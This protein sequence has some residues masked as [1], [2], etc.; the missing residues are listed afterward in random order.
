MATINK[1]RERERKE[2][3]T[4]RLL[5]Y[6]YVNYDCYRVVFIVVVAIVNELNV[7]QKDL[8]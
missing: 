5:L 3:E 1:E 8:M 4:G 7:T 2:K 6:E